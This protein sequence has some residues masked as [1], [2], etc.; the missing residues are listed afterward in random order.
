MSRCARQS[1]EEFSAQ[2]FGE[3]V[4]AIYLDQIERCAVR[5]ISA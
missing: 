1:A 3:R 5:R 2:R 4:E